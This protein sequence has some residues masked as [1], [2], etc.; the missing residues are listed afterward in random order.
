MVSI[1]PVP[2]LDPGPVSYFQFAEFTREPAAPA[3]LSLNTVVQPAGGPGTVVA[4]AGWVRTAATSASADNG[5]MTA[6]ALDIRRGL[7]PGETGLLP[8]VPNIYV[9]SC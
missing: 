7:R 3:K 2:K 9:A 4:E 8:M 5:V 1:S 6:A